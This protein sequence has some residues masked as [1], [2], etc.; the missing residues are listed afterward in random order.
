MELLELQNFANQALMWIG[1]GT[2]IGIIAKAVMPT[3]DEGGAIATMLMG[4]VGTLIGYAL[5]KF[6]YQGEAI[7]PIS[8]KGFFVGLC[9]AAVMLVLYKA[10]GGYW[11]GEGEN[12]SYRDRVRRRRRRRAYLDD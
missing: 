11:F 12:N 7:P 2:V 4:I 10:L 9:G 3:R 8:A 1:F 6:F 5:L